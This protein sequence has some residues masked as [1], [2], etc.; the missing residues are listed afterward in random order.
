MA[1]IRCEE[2]GETGVA[3][4]SPKVA[5]AVHSRST[6]S[7]FRRIEIDDPWSGKGSYLVDQEFVASLSADGLFLPGSET[8]ISDEAALDILS[9]LVPI[10]ADCFSTH[11]EGPD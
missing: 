6:L 3:F 5:I 1:A 7:G 8:P 2:H 11:H 9:R 4:V 10:C